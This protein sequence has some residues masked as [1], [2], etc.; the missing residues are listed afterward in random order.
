MQFI[1]STLRKCKMTQQ[2]KSV[3][4]K[5]TISTLLS[6]LIS[7][8]GLKLKANYECAPGIRECTID[9][10]WKFHGV[11]ITQDALS[12]A[13]SKTG[14]PPVRFT[15]RGAF[16]DAFLRWIKDLATSAKKLTDGIQTVIKETIVFL[17]GIIDPR[18]AEKMEQA[19]AA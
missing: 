14:Q 10:S 9:S 8:G 17:A 5:A 13:A 6:A 1:H 19:T 12:F 4:D 15:V 3:E 7:A 11:E 16:K 18:E 2:Q